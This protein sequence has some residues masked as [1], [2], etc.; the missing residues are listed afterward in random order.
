MNE[1]RNLQ[2][3]RVRD[4][5]KATGGSFT[6]DI[7][8]SHQS[9]VVFMWLFLTFILVALSVYLTQALMKKLESKLDPESHYF[10]TIL[11]FACVFGGLMAICA[12]A[13]HSMQ[14]SGVL[15]VIC[16]AVFMI[17]CINNIDTE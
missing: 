7:T 2:A 9:Q 8:L 5:E 3:Q 11:V 12:L 14:V 1:E 4:V 13:S 10:N 16:F 15:L 6:P 17:L